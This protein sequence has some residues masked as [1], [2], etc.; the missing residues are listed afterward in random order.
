MSRT[1]VVNLKG[2]RD[3]PHYADVVYVGRAMTR[4]GWYLEQSPLA[5]PFRLNRGS[6]V[7]HQV[8]LP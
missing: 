6:H 8:L 5:G 2:H 3:D 7:T 1:T 4:G